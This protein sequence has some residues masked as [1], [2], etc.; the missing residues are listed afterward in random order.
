MRCGWRVIRVCKRHSHRY[1]HSWR[2]FH[3]IAF[4]SF[5]KELR[6]SRGLYTAAWL[7][8][9]MFVKQFPQSRDWLFAY[10][11]IYDCIE[12]TAWAYSVNT[13]SHLIL[14]FRIIITH[15]WIHSNEYFIN[16]KPKKKPMSPLNN[17]LKSK[18]H[19]YIC[20]RVFW[21]KYCRS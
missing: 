20:L 21:T 16:L 4:L 5:L 9:S 14:L 10:S 2:T 19:P 15:Y 7:W 13:V 18:Y 6:C 3:S 12:P 1:I 8:G 11:A 17:I